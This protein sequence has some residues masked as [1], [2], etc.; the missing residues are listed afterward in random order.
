VTAQ[1]FGRVGDGI[2]HVV[3]SVALP[4]GAIGIEVVSCNTCGGAADSV[5][6]AEAEVLAVWSAVSGFL[7]ER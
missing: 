5:S 2:D 4:A 1:L 7:N 6:T 3:H